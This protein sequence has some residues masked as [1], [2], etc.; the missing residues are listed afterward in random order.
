MGFKDFV[1]SK[2]DELKTKF[3]LKNEQYQGSNADQLANFRIGARIKYG[4]ASYEHMYECSKDYV[5]KHI[6]YIES[7]NI[8]G[9]A[10]QDSLTD[11]ATYA[12]IMLYMRRC[13]EQQAKQEK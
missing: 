2:F 3:K 8:M 11:I 13:A 1:L 7:H 9:K 5:R 4:D 10:V 12:A 6:A